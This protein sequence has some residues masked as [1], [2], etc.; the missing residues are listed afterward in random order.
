MRLYGT[1]SGILIKTQTANKKAIRIKIV[2]FHKSRRKPDYGTT[3]DNNILLNRGIFQ[4][5]MIW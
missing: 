5:C 3:N 1:V 2:E 4:R